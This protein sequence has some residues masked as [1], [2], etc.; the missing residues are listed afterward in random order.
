MVILGCTIAIGSWLALF[1]FVMARIL[2]HANLIA[3]EEVCLREYGQ[4]YRDYMARVP[5]YFLFF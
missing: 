5:R 1:L 3:E 2:L 4:A